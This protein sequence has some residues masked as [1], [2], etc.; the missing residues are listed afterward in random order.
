[1]NK[2]APRFLMVALTCSVPGAGSAQ[3]ECDKQ[4]S[5]DGNYRLT[6]AVSEEGGPAAELSVVVAKAAFSIGAAD[7]R[8]DFTGTLARVGDSELFVE[9]RLNSESV[10]LLPRAKGAEATEGL[11]PRVERRQTST[12]SSVLL[13]LDEPVVI[14]RTGSWTFRLT[15]S[16]VP[17]D[18]GR[19]RD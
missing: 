3:T 16:R 14:A 8:V 5:L 13:Q 1:M 7:P 2:L 12:Q 18:G 10:V 6:L 19:N 11:G 15:V 17:A 4:P 9:Y